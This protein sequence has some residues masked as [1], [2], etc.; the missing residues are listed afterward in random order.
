MNDHLRLERF[1]SIIKKDN[2]MDPR[3]AEERRALI[4][5]NKKLLNQ[6][7]ESAKKIETLELTK[8]EM[9]EQLELLDFQMIE[10]E[11]RRQ[12]ICENS[13][14]QTEEDADSGPSVVALARAETAAA[15]SELA[16]QQAESAALA[17]RYRHLENLVRDLRRDNAELRE[18]VARNEDDSENSLAES[19]KHTRGQAL[20]VGVGGSGDCAELQR[21]QDRLRRACGLPEG[22]GDVEL[23]DGCLLLNSPVVQQ[24]AVELE[25]VSDPVT[26]DTLLTAIRN[27]KRVRNSLLLTGSRTSIKSDQTRDTNSPEYYSLQFSHLQSTKES[28]GLRAQ[29]AI[30]E[31][32]RV[33]LEKRV[34]EL[35]SDLS[36]AQAEYRA[37]EA[38]LTASRRNEAALRRRLLA[39]MDTG[40]TNQRGRPVCSVD[41]VLTSGTSPPLKED[42]D[43][44]T[45]VIRLEAAN[46][47]LTEASHLDRARLQDQATRIAQLEAEQRTLH[48]R[49]ASLQASESCAQRA[50]V[51]LQALYEDMLREFSEASTQD[52]SSAAR[53]RQRQTTDPRGYETDTAVVVNSNRHSADDAAMLKPCGSKACAEMRAVLATLQERFVRAAEQLTEAETLLAEVE[54]GHGGDPSRSPHA[55]RACPHLFAALRFAVECDRSCEAGTPTAGLLNRL[56]RWINAQLT[57][58]RTIE[59]EL[60][61]RCVDLQVALSKTS[62]SP[63]DAKVLEASLEAQ[64]SELADLHR[65]LEILHDE[66]EAIK[67][68]CEVQVSR[69]ERSP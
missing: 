48:D 39:T 47:A 6:L 37:N 28:D 5:Q 65:K 40:S 35:T 23:E 10:E 66:L 32:R 53:R 25:V 29:L 59:A 68:V 22:A 30:C 1:L 67:G 14:T 60:R 26:E 18:Q 15:L 61:Q 56:E 69:K 38:A 58:R 9:K 8:L 12:P 24:L 62:F 13:E 51:R 42:L 36:H 44:Q 17:A 7:Y 54:G 46:A 2:E 57:R 49:M 20:Q 11:L 21:L 63:N 4:R 34:Q 52:A 16:N 45:K 64:N 41:F 3:E 31:K 55:P 19:D 43:A 27:L 50:S 33:D